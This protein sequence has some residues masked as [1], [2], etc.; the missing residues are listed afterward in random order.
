VEEAGLHDR[1]DPVAHAGLGGNCQRVDDPEVDLL[2][3]E[4]PL[5]HGG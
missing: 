5:H 1:V 4:V 3:D 2:V